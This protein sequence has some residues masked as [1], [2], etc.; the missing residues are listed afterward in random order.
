MQW[1]KGISWLFAAG[2]ML[3]T[4]ACFN[5]GPRFHQRVY[6][7]GWQ[8]DPPFQEQIKD[9]S[10][11]GLAIEL[12]K[13]A[14][15][16]R[17]VRLQWV[18]YPPGPDAALRRK[19]VDLWPL[20]TIIPERKGVVY[21]SKPYLE[22][23]NVLLVR[24]DSPYRGRDDLA[25]ARVSLNDLPINQRLLRSILP[26]AELLRSPTQKASIEDLC[27]HRSEAAFLD[28]FTADAVL[29]SGLTCISQPVRVISVPGLRTALGVGATLESAPVADE[30]RRGLDDVAAEGGLDE[31]L[32]KFGQL[33][34][35]NLAYFSE[36]RTA[37]RRERWLLAALAIFAVL[38]GLSISAWYRI[39]IQKN[40]IAMAEGAFRESE[41]KLRLLAN[42]LNE[43][44]LA[45]DMQRNLVFS[46]P[47][48]ER[49]T[50][51]PA[52]EIQ[53][54]KALCWVHPDDRDRVASNWNSLFTGR[55]Y[56]DLEYRMVTRDGEVK[57]AIASWG[58][59]LGD[60]GRQIGV[61]G[62]EREITERKLAEQALSESERQFRELLEGVHLVAIVIDVEGIVRFCNDYALA[63]TSWS[64]E[65]VIGRPAADFLDQEVLR[66][67]HNESRGGKA[68]PFLEGTIRTTTGERCRIQW[69][70]VGLRNSAGRPAG[71]ACLGADITELETLR[72]ESAKRESDRRFRAIADNAPLMIWVAVPGKGCAFVN[73]G[74]LDFTGRTLEQELGEGWIDSIH[75][76]DVET[77]LSRWESAFASRKS[78][79]VQCRKRRQ[80]GEY[81]WVLASAVPRF[82]PNNE[83]DGYVGTFTD[84][85]ELRRAHDETI[86]RQKLETVVLLASGIAHD[87]NNLLGAVVAQADLAIADFAQHSSPLEP[88]QNIRT[89]ALRGSRIVRQLMIFAGQEEAASEELDLSSVVEESMDLLKVVVSKHAV[90]KTDLCKPLPAINANPSQIRQVLMNLV[91][92]A[93]EAIGE[94][95]GLITVRTVF[96]PRPQDSLADSPA[97]YVRLE[98][99]DTGR[100]MT[101][102]EQARVFDPFF[103][104]K[105][106]GHGLGLPVV[107]GIVRS[108]GG[109]IHLDTEV[110]K[111][112][113]FR[114]CFL[115]TGRPAPAVLPA[116][117]SPSAKRLTHHGLVLVVEDESTLL[118]ASAAI[119][120]R[121]G[122]SVLEAADGNAALNLI[123]QHRGSIALLL[124]DITLPG[125]P[126]RDV[127]V[128]ARLARSDMKI[129]VTSA[130][131]QNAVDASFAGLGIDA[132]L[133][134]PY[135]LANLV[136]LTGK[137]I[138]A[139]PDSSEKEFDPD[140]P[141]QR[142]AASPNS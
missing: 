34:L 49:I 83:F 111:G 132:F 119:L 47:A 127:L 129:I 22:H 80:D 68:L 140:G 97:E 8:S 31:V 73:K 3:A 28:E 100:G 41:Q 96:V 78:F 25:T 66:R 130:Y 131:G 5:A 98:V 16:K 87:F 108:L 42:S 123:R 139:E 93:S 77:Y 134:K 105:S 103:T 107:Q 13:D 19:D 6:R 70:S 43:V 9:D 30:I 65:Q 125:A 99:S 37:G 50:R 23:E 26:Q 53:Q 142:A 82:G 17:G 114:L 120:R 115:S 39:R 116:A 24:S 44:V 56:R 126:S 104:T 136:E 133:R 84:I 11:S 91:I 48:L 10:P 118:M 38:L 21:I 64:R 67:L 58:P 117:P 90:L 79:H 35:R 138:S 124:L 1:A 54:Q 69:S 52:E 89:V 102:D 15:R 88:L 72:A 4:Y 74:W 60:D 85:T 62:T 32:S 14:A 20:V 106:P 141:R 94:R 27:A 92:N 135:K 7:I 36:L 55:S 29:F 128:T 40:R 2:S 12:V 95:D 33:S 101:L 110:G 63:L 86:A 51:Y 112:S 109:S 137:L 76:A 57:W 122:Y 59:M 46:N 45:F 113:T 61:Y 71:V 81:R 121:H 75:P 18:W